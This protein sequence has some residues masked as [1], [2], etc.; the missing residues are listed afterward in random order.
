MLKY[1]KLMLFGSIICQ[2][3]KFNRPLTKCASKIL[4]N[5]ADFVSY[6]SSYYVVLNYHIRNALI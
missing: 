4:C 1:S 5:V 3:T 2:K 6:H